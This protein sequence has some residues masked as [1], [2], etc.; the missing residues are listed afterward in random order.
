M[1]TPN[2]PHLPGLSVLDRVASQ[3]KNATGISNALA[4]QQAKRST[5]R[6]PKPRGSIFQNVGN[7]LFDRKT[8]SDTPFLETFLSQSADNPFR[9][10]FGQRSRP[11]GPA[12]LKT[13]Y[14]S[15]FG[16]ST[17]FGG[18]ATGVVALKKMFGS[19]PLAGSKPP[20]SPTA[21]PNGGSGTA[22]DG[23]AG[24]RQWD[25]VLRQVARESGVPYE[26]LASIMAIESGGKNVGAND[27]G[28]T[29]LMQVV[30]EYWQDTANKYGGDLMDPYTNVRTA[31][32]I[33]KSGYDTY[34]NNWSNAAA[35][36][37]GGGGAFANGGYSDN[38]DYFGT[39]ISTYVGKFN[40]NMS[41]FSDSQQ[42]MSGSPSGQ[43]VFPVDGYG[44]D[45]E[46][47]WGQETGAIDLFAGEGTA[48]RSMTSGQVVSGYSEIGGYWAILYG[49]DGQQYY[50]AHMQGPAYNGYVSAGQQIGAVGATGNA[51][52]TGAHLHLGIGSSINNGTGPSGGAGD[53]D[54]IGI[55]SGSY[56]Y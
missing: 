2:S 1:P 17:A 4:V 32:D 44:G 6:P 25:S 27:A 10:S 30:P 36:F 40:D 13:R 20:A 37:F 41:Y 3:W 45:L 23:V 24:V 7:E 29:G 49:D 48:V 55:L 16:G 53:A 15:P 9:Q 39:D 8:A 52:G 5:T 26:V 28:A 56:R 35:F 22:S 33:L 14:A 50:Y 18:G 54:V 47:H 42:Q 46:L 21:N 51:A 43:Y 11:S 12:Q 31:A 38:A 34:G 19:R